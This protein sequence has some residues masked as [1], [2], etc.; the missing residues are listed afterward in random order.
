MS[1]KVVSSPIY[2]A[3]APVGKA[4]KVTPMQSD[5]VN[6]TEEP[7]ISSKGTDG[8]RNSQLKVGELKVAKQPSGLFEFANSDA[9]KQRVRDAKL[10]KDKYN[11]HNEYHTTGWM[12]RIARN[13]IFENVTLT[14]ICMNVVWIAID[15]DYNKEPYHD[16]DGIFDPKT[17]AVWVVADFLFF[18]F[19]TAELI[20]RFLAFK[21]KVRCLQDA[22]FVFD[23]SLVILYAFDPFVLGVLKRSGSSFDP[24][25]ST[26]R[27]L[28]LARLSRLVRM[29][30]F[31]PELMIMIKGMVTA[32][33]TVSYTLGLLLVITYVFAIMLTQLT[34]PK[35]DDT[36]I[37]VSY[38]H[39]TYFEG[40]AK[41]MYSLI[42]YATFLDNLADF[43]GAIKE[44]S[45]LCLA[46]VTVFVG[47]A[48]LTVMNMLIGVL[49][50]VISAVAQE[51]KE[52]LI[53]D[54]V[55]EKFQNIVKEIDKDNDGMLSWNEFIKIMDVPEAVAQL[56]SVGV[57]PEGMI[58][59]AQD[60]FQEDGQPKPISFPD[61]M[62]IVLDLRGTQVATLKDLMTMQKHVNGK[63]SALK[64]RLE[65][66]DKVLE[67]CLE[68][69]NGNR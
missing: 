8:A 40:V 36:E 62:N 67:D 55:Q 17:P 23:T 59:F 39:V 14:V 66:I 44:E 50:E 26:V 32:A 54:K 68:E 29:L 4:S 53:T 46:V 2:S 9:I 34:M 31:L 3:P 33:S 30:R 6:N 41:S 64:G 11:V 48:N 13:Q 51:E 18:G 12:Q 28:R 25:T 56:D 69:D 20:I 19:F 42:I 52:Q 38:I 35:Y 10:K 24:P 7:R 21:R 49:C 16:G 1:S 65:S 22:W 58:D 57:D 27:L 5:G 43:C 15:T 63:F 47:L 37:H 45:S 60:W 61:F